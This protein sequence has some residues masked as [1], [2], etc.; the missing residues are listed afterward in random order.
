VPKETLQFDLQPERNTNEVKKVIFHMKEADIYSNSKRLFDLVSSGLETVRTEALHC[1]A[2]IAEALGPDAEDYIDGLINNMFQ[3]GLSEDLISCL[4]SIAGS[5]PTKAYE[6]ENRLLQELS[7][8]LAGTTAVKEICDPLIASPY[9]IHDDAMQYIHD[10]PTSRKSFTP[11]L[12]I[13]M[14]D[15]PAAITRLQLALRTLR[16]F[17]NIQSRKALSLL[18][19]VRDVVA[20]Y[21]L[22]PS[23]DV[24][25]EAALTCCSVL[26]PYQ[27]NELSRDSKRLNESSTTVDNRLGIAST[28]VLEEVLQKLLRV[29]VSDASPRVRNCIV[30]AFDERYDSYL[31]QTSHLPPLFLLIQDEALSVRVASLELLGRLARLNPAPILPEMRKLLVE[32]ITELQCSGD[33]GTR[34]EAVTRLLICFFKANALHRIVHPF[35]QSIIEVLPLRGGAPRVTTAALEALGELAQIDKEN[36][37]PWLHQL[38]PLILEIMRDQSSTNQ[39]RICLKT[40]GRLAASTGYIIDPYLDYPQ[41]LSQAASILP[42]T[43]KAPWALRQEVIRVFGIIGALDPDQFNQTDS[44]GR[45]GRGT[46]GIG[47]GY[48]VSSEDITSTQDTKSSLG[49]VLSVSKT[50]PISRLDSLTHDREKKSA[51]KGQIDLGKEPTFAPKKTRKSEDDDTDPAHLCMYELYTMTAQP[52]SRISPA[53]RLTPLDDGFYPTVALQALTSILKD[54]S[55]AAH[56]QEAMTAIMFI[57]NSLGLRCVPFLKNIVPHIL[58]IA[59]VQAS[60]RE[61]LLQQ[62]A[63]LSGIVKENFQPYVP[64]IFDIVIEFWNTK[65]LATILDLVK[66]IAIGVPVAFKDYVPTLTTRFLTSLDLFSSACWK[67][68]EKVPDDDIN[69]LKLI[70]KSISALRENLVDHIHLLLPALL[71]LIESLIHC[72]LRNARTQEL[73]KSAIETMA[74][75]LNTETHCTLKGQQEQLPALVAQPLIRLLSVDCQGRKEV[76]A[77]IVSCLCICAKKM[78]KVRWISLF[79]CAARDAIVT[80]NSYFAPYRIT[81]IA[82]NDSSEEY[83]SSSINY[84]ALKMYDDLMQSFIFPEQSELASTDDPET[85]NALNA[86]GLRYRSLQEILTPAAAPNTNQLKLSPINLKNAW[87]VSQKTTREDWDEWMRKFAISLLREAPAPS[88]RSTAELAYAYQP[89]ARELFSAAFACCWNELNDQYRADLIDSLKTV[90]FADASPEILQTLLNLAEYAERDGLPGGLPIEIDILAELALKCRSYAKALHYKEK[91]HEQGDAGNCIADLITI[92]KKLD[93]PEAALGVLKAAQFELER[94]GTSSWYQFYSRSLRDQSRTEFSSRIFHRHRGEGLAYSITRSSDEIAGIVVGGWENVEMQES[95]LS[96]LGSW[97]DALALYENRLEEN[98]NDVEA[99]LGCMNCLNARGEWNRVLELADQSHVA[100]QSNAHISLREKR[101]AMDYCAQASWRLGKWADLEK[102]SNDLLE[103]N[104]DQYTGSTSTPRLDFDG[105]FYSA[106]LNIH[107][108]EW[109]AA[110]TYIDA[111]RKAMDS[112]FTAL[113]AESRKR[114][115]PS[116]VTAQI[117]A[118]MEEIISFR[119]LEERS[120]C[121]EDIHIAN[122]EDEKEARERLINLWRKRLAGCRADAEVHSSVLAVRSLVLGPTDEVDATLTLSALSRQAQAY[123]ISERVLLDPLEQLGADLNSSIFGHSISESIKFGLFNSQE[124]ND[125]NGIRSDELILKIIMEENGHFFPSYSASHSN[126]CKKLIQQAGGVDRIYVQHKLYFAYLKH[127]WLM[128]NRDEALNR[129]GLLANV[130]D[131]IAHFEGQAMKELR[132]SCWLK[133]SEWR[134][135]SAHNRDLSLTSST[136]TEILIALKRATFQN[137][138]GYKSWHAWSLF[139]FRL[140]QQH[141]EVRLNNKKTRPTTAISSLEKTNSSI[142]TAHVIASV[143]GFVKAICFGTKRWSASVLQDLLNFLSC[144]FKYGHDEAVAA[145]VTQEVELVALEAWLGVLP[146]LLARIQISTPSIRTILHNLLIRLGEKHPQALMYPLSVLIKSPVTERR[147]SAESLMN[148]LKKHSYGLVGDA[149]MVSSELI[150]VAILWLEQ[151]HEGLEDASRLYYGEGNVSAMLEVLMPLHEALERGPSTHREQDFYAQ[152]GRDLSQ[153]HKNVKEYVRLIQLDGGRIPTQGGFLNSEQTDQ[154][155]VTNPRQKAEDMLNQAWDLYYSVFRRINKQLPG[156]T[157]LELSQCSPALL[158]AHHLELGVPGSYRVDG[159]FVKIESFY[160]SVQV[161]TSKQR[162]RKIVLRGEDGK[163]Y[164]FLLKGHEDLRQDER[165]M[166]LFGLVNALLARD[167][168]TNNHH[169]NIQ[170]Y[171]I[172]PL[173]HNAGIVGWVPHCDTIHS[174]IRDYRASKMIPLNMENREMLKL[175]QDYEFLTVM[176]KVEVFSDAL[177]QTTGKG[178]DIHEVLWIN[179]TN[180]EEWLERRTN[181]TRSIAVMSMVGY[182]LGLGDVSIFSIFFLTSELPFYLSNFVFPL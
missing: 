63:S 91:E 14:Q 53:Q 33:I 66:K 35:L 68:K 94:N 99:L 55:L 87:D 8:S 43:K 122:R 26:L 139:N 98:P 79:H 10:F 100:L 134:I 46:G 37:N 181:F 143:K 168:R 28:T 47:S 30:R 107:R 178:N 142:Q 73:C 127:L 23:Q 60:L 147:E 42:A 24:R 20:Q 67:K 57:F 62:I 118:E 92:N 129:L 5:S 21:L 74:L 9:N 109:D 160:P 140:A 78:G 27:D 59:R 177:D 29:A 48:F 61:A 154:A 157:T 56:H 115:Y 50:L 167:R 161:I 2:D 144:L 173:S 119:Q 138:D 34:K 156:L 65:H 77:S 93:L 81:S 162:P 151:W 39:Q 128:N 137:Y 131:L 75:L 96:K 180:S 51:P 135:D 41:L 136:Q 38:V 126:Y 16:S 152:F 170:R 45:K 80:W 44:S 22:H 141:D 148:S 54:P 12:S 40:L 150:R 17:G 155:S 69:R 124:K 11:K 58:H 110:S 171:T 121:Y 64:A 70:I 166:Q 163:D 82:N 117:L 158:Q 19:F 13:N 6:I 15:N 31:C 102:Y 159:S 133:V 97:A 113:M 4:K 36:L 179:S 123:K 7:M 116:M 111:A 146:Q 86:D 182:I 101:K 176:Q 88:L 108:K 165:V 174:L 85:L 18:P 71:K 49:S 114:A 145:V 3:S 120:K 72:G 125:S 104:P 103:S 112:R 130:V 83:D 84:K 172:T 1:G 90:F 175:T 164:V 25:K 32:L 52:V 76:G 132:T 169:L 89:L 106:I 95:W 149:L 153:A 105:S